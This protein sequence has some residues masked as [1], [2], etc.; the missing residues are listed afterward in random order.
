MSGAAAAG[1]AAV[2]EVVDERIADGTIPGATV[3]VSEGGGVVHFEAKGEV[4]TVSARPLTADT[5]YWLAS[6]TK[7]V[8]AAAVL[9][10]AEDGA[11]GL[12]DEVGRH[13]PEFTER[14]RVRVWERPPPPVSPF[15]PPPA[16]LPGFH[17]EPAD[18]PLTL[19]DL[20]THTGGLQSIFT[21]NPEFSLPEPADSLASYAPRLATIPLDFQPGT[22][23]AYS[24]AASFDVLGRVVEVVSGSSL[25]A[26]LHERLFAPLGLESAAFGDRVDR[27]RAMPLADPFR[28]M[29][30]V[31][32]SY[33]S[34]AAG[35]WMTAQDYVRFA[36]MLN[37]GGEDVMSAETVAT[38]VSNHVGDLMTTLM[39]R[40]EPG[41]LG[42]GMGVVTI[43][44]AAASDLRMPAGSFGWD[45]IATRRFWASPGEQR[46]LFMYV[47]EP[48]VQAEIEA[49]VWNQG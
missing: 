1:L 45:G 46:V 43:E 24:N 38:M 16:D 40:G 14:P 18:R 12:S 19:T 4:D 31:T 6:L 36:E 9:I 28:A 22:Q 21:Y 48:S 42:F 5:I 29:P 34:G 10:L 35:L 49:A 8:I 17:F 33:H 23:W 37:S 11:L 3:V 39:G 25:D 26:F 20:L 7:P 13:L 30:T 2:S 47:P 32:G 44:D 27:A 15:G 41:G